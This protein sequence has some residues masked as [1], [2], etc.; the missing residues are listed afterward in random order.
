MTDA[1]WAAADQL[2]DRPRARRKIIFLISDGQNV[3]NNTHKYDET[4][5]LLLSNDISVY[6]VGVGEANLN[7]GI[8]FLD[9]NI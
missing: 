5:Q 4:L 8:T 3:K 7:R 1:I 9:K 2:K 6:A